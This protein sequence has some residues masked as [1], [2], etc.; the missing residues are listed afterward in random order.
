VAY[1]AA[2]RATVLLNYCQLGTDLIDYVV[3]VSPLRFGKLVPGVLVPIVHPDVF[4]ENN[5]DYA[6]LTAWNYEAEVRRNERDFLAAG[7]RLIVPLPD[8][9]VVGAA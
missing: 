3:D 8:V 2:G 1:G 9:R 4:R 5:P 7:G 6:L